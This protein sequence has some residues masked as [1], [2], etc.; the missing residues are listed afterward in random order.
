M[1]VSKFG[2]IAVLCC[3]AMI[4]GIPVGKRAPVEAIV[5]RQSGPDIGYVPY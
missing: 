4:G 1:H 5:R 3:I 2:L